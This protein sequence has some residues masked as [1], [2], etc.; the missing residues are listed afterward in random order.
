[1]T[2]FSTAGAFGAAVIGLL[3]ATLTGSSGS[4][5][6]AFI[7]STAVITLLSLGL[8]LTVQPLSKPLTPP[9]ESESRLHGQPGGNT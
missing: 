6:H 4:P 1:M 9:T 2:A 5:L 8:S 7:L 3:D